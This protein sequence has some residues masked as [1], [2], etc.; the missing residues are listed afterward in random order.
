MGRNWAEDVHRFWFEE[1]GEK[2]WF[3]VR[4]STDALIRD[5]FAPLYAK[6]LRALPV[7]ALR[8]PGAALSAVIVYDQFPRNMFRG[9][10]EAFGSDDLALAV[11]RHAV[12][13]GFDRGLSKSERQFLYMPFMHSELIADQ[14]RCVELFAPLGQKLQRFAIDHRDIVARFG[15][16]PHRNRV[17]GRE[18][19]AEEAA[20][21][22]DHAGYGQ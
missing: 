14:D 8:A 10:A 5:R 18:T 19:S 21:L 9:A 22:K 17:L 15:R 13:R 6:H 3:E 12:L 4:K 1:L 7:A 11:S 2:D 20:F 16:F